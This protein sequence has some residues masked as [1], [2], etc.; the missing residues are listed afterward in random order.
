VKTFYSAQDIENLA[1]QG[2]RELL[3][4][5]NSVL[6]DLARDAA[7][8][9]G[10]K[11]V[12]GRQQSVRPASAL[13]GMPGSASAPSVARPKGCQHGPLSGGQAPLGTAGGNLVVD[14]LVGA[15]KQLAGRQG[16]KPDAFSG[17]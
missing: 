17:G 13:P 11:L 2:V 9:L 8:Q 16:S 4:D 5:E 1:A 12:S 14:E 6:T 3:L 7:A 10:L 15:V